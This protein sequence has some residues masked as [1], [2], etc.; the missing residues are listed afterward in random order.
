MKK[1]NKLFKGMSHSHNFIITKEMMDGFLSIS[2]DTNK[3][4]TDE[5]FAKINKFD[6]VVVYGG[7]LI[8]QI[9]YLIGVHIPGERSIWNGVKINFKSPLMI[10]TPAVLKATITHVSE[11]TS[12]IEMKFDITSENNV[13]AN[14]SVGATII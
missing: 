3:L 9:S 7:L 1:I 12:S 14:G 6:G 13:V 10:N 8:A 11:A 4:H 5:N 2:N